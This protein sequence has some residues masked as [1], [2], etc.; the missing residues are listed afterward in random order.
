MLSHM[1]SILSKGSEKD[2]TSVVRSDSGQLR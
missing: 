2:K 1:V